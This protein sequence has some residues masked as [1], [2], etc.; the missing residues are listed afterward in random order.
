MSTV[1]SVLNKIYVLKCD[2]CCNHI[3]NLVIQ[4]GRGKINHQEFCCDCGGGRLSHRKLATR[5]LANAKIRKQNKT[6]PT[7]RKRLSS[8]LT[9]SRLFALPALRVVTLSNDIPHGLSGRQEPRRFGHVPAGRQEVLRAPRALPSRGAVARAGAVLGGSPQHPAPL[10]LSGPLWLLGDRK[11]YNNDNDDDDDGGVAGA[12]AG[13]RPGRAPRCMHG[14]GAGPAAATH[15]AAPP[16]PPPGGRGPG[17]NPR[18]PRRAGSQ[19]RPRCGGRLPRFH[20]P[21]CA[22]GPAGRAPRRAEPRAGHGAGKSWGETGAGFP[23]P[24]ER[25]F[26]LSI[27]P[28]SLP[29][30][31]DWGLLA[32]SCAPQMLGKKRIDPTWGSAGAEGVRGP[33]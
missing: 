11:G 31:P 2:G 24:A 6:T 8:A 22:R 4:Y 23:S 14:A 3:S 30:S 20:R 33:S 16:P 25:D 1:T 29:P 28:P 21:G 7:S 18:P 17:S 12:A 26:V 32:V 10:R 9:C 5:A 27:P 15:G 13:E 19:P